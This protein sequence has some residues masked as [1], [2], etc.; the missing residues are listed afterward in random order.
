MGQEV[1]LE[2]LK[3]Y[4]AYDEEAAKRIRDAEVTD[5]E[6]YP[7]HLGEDNLARRHRGKD[8]F[9][10]SQDGARKEAKRWVQ[11]IKTEDVD[12]IYIYGIGL[13]YYYD[14][15]KGW[16]HKDPTRFVVFLESDYS[17]LNMLFNT[18]KG[19]EIL[20]DNQV[21]I[22]TFSIEN[23][24]VV[25]S[26]D[27]RCYLLFSALHDKSIILSSLKS[28][29][30]VRESL[31]LGIKSQIYISTSWH[32]NVC[33]DKL[34]YLKDIT[35]NI[36]SNI[37]KLEN[38]SSFEA[39]I[40]GFK[41]VPAIITGAGPSVVN[42]IHLFDEAKK[43]CLLIGSGTG[44][45]VLNSHGIL[46]H[47]F[48]GI[49]PTSSQE[50]R[51]RMNNSYMVPC[52]HKARFSADASRFA[53][54]EKVYLNHCT[55]PFSTRW[56][57]D[58]IGIRQSLELEAGIS[59]TTFAIAIAHA[60]GCNPIILSGLDLAYTDN[61]RYP[62][63]LR[64]IS[65]GSKAVQDELLIKSKT[66]L[67][68]KGYEGQEVITKIDWLVEGKLISHFKSNHPE[69]TLYNATRGG[70]LIEQ[71]ANVSLGEFL[72]TRSKEY[73]IEGRLHALIE[74]GAI[75]GSS[76]MMPLQAVLEWKRFVEE[77]LEAIQTERVFFKET[78]SDGLE[79]R[80]FGEAMQSGFVT[81][82]KS[83]PFFE[84]FL[85][86]HEEL[87]NGAVFFKK[88]N[89]QKAQAKQDTDFIRQAAEDFAEALFAFWE[90]VAREHL[91]GIEEAL[92]ENTET[93][94]AIES[95]ARPVIFSEESG[96]LKE[97]TPAVFEYSQEKEGFLEGRS[98][99]FSEKRQLLSS[100]WY[101]RGNLEGAQEFFY[102]SGRLFAKRN[103]VNGR[104][105]GEQS[106]F[107][108]DGSKRAEMFYKEGKLDGD[109]IIYYPR[110]R[111]NRFL[112][113]K[114]GK[115]SG[116]ERFWSARGDLLFSATYKDGKP[117]GEALEYYRHDK[118]LRRTVF[119]DFGKRILI[120]EFSENGQLLKEGEL[121][122]SEEVA[123]PLAAQD[124]IENYLNEMERLHYAF[125]GERERH[126]F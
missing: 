85:E 29:S 118:L 55:S 91:Q 121:T 12:L 83:N 36:I 49:D 104:L 107:F 116:T 52:F 56:F 21:V 40:G 105:E 66:P 60:M 94:S 74:S 113:F 48:V 62:E 3:L 44:T 102:R 47:F 17:A 4:A 34:T 64:P 101:S 100:S 54:G 13:G 112:Q 81:K 16:L 76:T 82:F 70:L 103:F 41:D 27:P 33:S 125:G 39:L 19:L 35:R 106:Y 7:T 126:F 25:I 24:K 46:P 37:L 14:E 69:V 22:Q 97:I 109:V 78:L 15:I 73:D 114:E 1:L 18:P 45:N 86:S 53:T 80:R 20:K 10:H 30:E 98:C 59:S 93:S 43:R 122:P 28:Y 95:D 58:A 75:R 32:R 117:C 87:M 63:V 124:A 92:S 57:E 72:K 68:D 8:F 115:L 2:C 23:F 123:M 79:S 50:S 108:D 38:E 26:L 65:H 77:F 90:N 119:D 61:K 88:V 120:E 67:I 71:V 99:F 42:D 9:F 5:Y 96:S 111:L 84:T 110:G 89:L 6:I 51:I 31:L 11:N